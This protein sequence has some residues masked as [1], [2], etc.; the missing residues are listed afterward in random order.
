MRVI[1]MSGAEPGLR[2]GLRTGLAQRRRKQ[3]R[4]EISSIHKVCPYDRE[5][6]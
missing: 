2:E 3:E 6:R 4:K 1:F 5:K